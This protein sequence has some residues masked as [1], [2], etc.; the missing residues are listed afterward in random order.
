MAGRVLIADDQ[1]DVLEALRLL[2]SQYDFTVRL[3]TSPKAL[4]EQVN[5]RNL[6]HRADGPELLARHHV[7]RR[8][9]AGARRGPRGRSGVADRRH[10]RLGQPYGSS[11]ITPWPLDSVT[12]PPRLRPTC[13]IPILTTARPEAVVDFSTTKVPLSDDRGAAVFLRPRPAGTA[14]PA[15]RESALGVDGDRR[16]AVVDHELDRPAEHDAG[17]VDRELD[18]EAAGEAGRGDRRVP[19]ETLTMKASPSARLAATRR[20]GGGA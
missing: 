2:L 4:L 13:D 3:V 12:T 7:G 1:P 6:G 20:V 8:G 11:R 19:V 14:R 10:D 18:R 16:R 5:G 17:H 15:R 9:P